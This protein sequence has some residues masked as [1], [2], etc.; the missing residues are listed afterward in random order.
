LWKP[1]EA[2]THLC[3]F[4]INRLTFVM[5][6]PTATTTRTSNLG[7]RQS[8]LRA[9][10]PLPYTCT[11]GGHVDTWSLW[12]LAVAVGGG[13]R[14]TGQCFTCRGVAKI[15]D[16]RPSLWRPER[17][18]LSAAARGFFCRRRVKVFVNTAAHEEITAPVACRTSV[19]H[20]SPSPG[21]ST[22]QSEARSTVSGS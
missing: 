21:Q 14:S 9:T 6:F 12:P 18:T 8:P 7:L 5:F 4:C 22:C 2:Y 11:V 16:S 1:V 10:R 13:D 3:T 20:H 17:I 19:C 15:T